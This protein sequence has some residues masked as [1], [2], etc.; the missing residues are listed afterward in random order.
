MGDILVSKALDIA[1]YI[2][3]KCTIESYPISNLQL[4]KIMYYIQS[5]SLRDSKS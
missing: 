3:N 5:D 1:E 4:Q 2:I